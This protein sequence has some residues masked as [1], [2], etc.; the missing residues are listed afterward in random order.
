MTTSSACVR[1][2]S[3][4]KDAV[5]N[6]VPTE[7]ACAKESVE[8]LGATQVGWRRAKEACAPSEMK[9]NVLPSVGFSSLVS[10]FTAVLVGH[11]GF[12]ARAKDVL[13]HPLPGPTDYRPGEVFS[14]RSGER[15]RAEAA[16][17][18][19]DVG[20]LDGGGADLDEEVAWLGRGFGESLDAEV[21]GWAGFG[22]AEGLYGG[23]G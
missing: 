4:V 18:V 23:V 3:S 20:G 14:E 10:P 9:L 17:G 11:G 22:D 16:A 6:R 19:E 8:G 7:A 5:V 12:T 21:V 2:R 13:P 1:V 15:R